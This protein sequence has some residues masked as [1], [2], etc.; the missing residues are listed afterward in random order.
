[1][2]ISVS[3]RQSV[4]LAP[5][6]R[7]WPQ[8]LVCTWDRR[9]LWG[10]AYSSFRA[11]FKSV[12]LY[13]NYNMMPFRGSGDG[14]CYKVSCSVLPIC[15]DSPNRLKLFFFFLTHIFATPFFPTRCM[16]LWGYMVRTQGDPERTCKLP[17][18]HPHLRSGC[19]WCGKLDTLPAPTASPEPRTF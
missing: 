6:G 5:L 14:Y 18:C 7:G 3:H 4:S 11:K 12:R 9:W 17:F 8:K 13:E 15:C 19:R 16:F 1:M 10:N 2:S